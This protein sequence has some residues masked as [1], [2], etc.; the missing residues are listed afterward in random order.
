MQLRYIR[1]VCNAINC[2]NFTSHGNTVDV[3][4]VFENLGRAD[5]LMV[6]YTVYPAT[7]HLC[8]V[9]HMESDLMA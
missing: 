5:V 3:I 8:V 4:N 6:D 9:L 1:H 7:I 2:G